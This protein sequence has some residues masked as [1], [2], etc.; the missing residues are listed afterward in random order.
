MVQGGYFAYKLYKKINGCSTVGELAEKGCPICG[1]Q[2]FA[3]ASTG[4]G[5]LYCPDHE[6]I[7]LWWPGKEKYGKASAAWK[8]LVTGE[9]SE[10]FRRRLKFC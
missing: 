10:A 8:N 5:S 2:L 1:K 7:W 3:E 4:F 9:C 6:C